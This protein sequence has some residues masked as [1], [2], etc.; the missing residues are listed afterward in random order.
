VRQDRYIKTRLR[1]GA[2]TFAVASLNTTLHGLPDLSIKSISV[3][4]LFKMLSVAIS[5]SEKSN[6]T[7]KSIIA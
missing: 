6:F 4:S 1:F 3:I 7:R 5:V 2:I